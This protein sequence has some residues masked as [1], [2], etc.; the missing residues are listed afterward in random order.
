M[1]GGEEKEERREGVTKIRIFVCLYWLFFVI[2]RPFIPPNPPKKILPKLAMLLTL[3][4]HLL[5][6]LTPHFPKLP[7]ILSPSPYTSTSPN[8]APSDKHRKIKH[9]DTKLESNLS[10]LA[11]TLSEINNSNSSASPSLDPSVLQRPSLRDATFHLPSDLT[12]LTN[13]DINSMSEYFT[14]PGYNHTLHPYYVHSL[15]KKAT[16]ILTS[17]PPILH[18]HPSPQH[19]TVVGDIHGSLPDLLSTFR[20]TG[21]PSPSNNYIFNGDYVDR[22][23]HGVEVLCLL[24]SFLVKGAGET[25]YMHRGNHE[26]T[27]V[28]TAYGFRDE[29]RHKYP[30][31]EGLI[32]SAFGEL[33]KELPMG[34]IIDKDYNG[35][36]V[37]V[38]GGLGENTVLGK[39]V[40]SPPSALKTEG[41][42]ILWSD[43]DVEVA[44]FRT[45]ESRGN[46]GSF[47]GLD[48]VDNTCG[49]LGVR[50]FVRR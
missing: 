42:E 19:I 40:K 12:H 9:A 23:P 27:H 22:G 44:G 41:A 11:S 21:Y 46:T 48:V 39:V 2:E 43:P 47:Y 34:S 37:V 29:V 24:L 49:G 1:P 45:N 5:R 38:H 3:S 14:S 20:L 30:E 17:L 36:A 35:G 16:S 33:C 8:F 31:H 4:P 25:L 26:D 15:F 32:W 6:R 28:S 7:A 50:H 13:K 18:H 10:F